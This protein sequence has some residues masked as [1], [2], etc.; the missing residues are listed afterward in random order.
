MR[1][2]A[3]CAFALRLTV[4]IGGWLSFDDLVFWDGSKRMRM[5]LRRT[6]FMG[7]GFRP[8]P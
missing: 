7:S 5:R 8:P 6:V 3:R 1:V 2:G 4:V